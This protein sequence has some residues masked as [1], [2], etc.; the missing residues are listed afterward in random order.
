[1]VTD[2]CVIWATGE[3]EAIRRVQEELDRPYGFL[4][5]WTTIGTDMDVVSI[6]SVLDNSEPAQVSSDGSILLPVSRDQINAF[7]E[8]NAHR[9]LAEAVRK[10]SWIKSA[11]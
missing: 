8:A 11:Y 1:M 9:I 3:E 4:G 5:G 7:I 2:E 10:T 6:E